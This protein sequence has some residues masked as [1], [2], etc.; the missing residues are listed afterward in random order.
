[1]IEKGDTKIS[2][3]FLSMLKNILSEYMAPPCISQKPI[4]FEIEEIMNEIVFDDL[5]LLKDFLF[6]KMISANVR[7]AIGEMLVRKGVDCRQELELNIMKENAFEW[8][9]E[10]AGLELLN[11]KT[12]EAANSITSRYKH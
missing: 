4:I 7:S 1:M 11:A 5:I 10:D 3:C 9:P 6:G 8:I 12:Y 2:A